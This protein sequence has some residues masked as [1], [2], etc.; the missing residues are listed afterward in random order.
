MMVSTKGR[1]ALR[2][3]IDLAEHDDGRFIPLKEIAARQGISEKYLESIV[4][5]LARS[6]DL[7]GMRGKGGGYRLT[8]APEEY[9]VGSI[10][11]LTEGGLV[12][13]NC[14]G[15]SETERCGRSA[16]CP[17]FPLWKGLDDVVNQYLDGITLAELLPPE[18]ERS[19]RCGDEG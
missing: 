10:L 5:L 15:L 16:D 1:Y 8:R 12:P 7:F 4:K 11:R 3:L 6:G 19:C 17:T 14:Q 13:V 9:T 18:G 2:V